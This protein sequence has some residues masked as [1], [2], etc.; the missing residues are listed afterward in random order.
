MEK[1]AEDDHKVLLGMVF[2]VVQGVGF[3]MFVRRRAQRLGLTGW[4]RNTP[5]GAVAV[6]AHG[7]LYRLHELERELL[8]GPPGSRVTRV[9]CDI[10][11]P[12]FEAPTSFDIL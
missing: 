6:Q 4:V 5:E 7:S 9:L 3:R 2:G 11:A 10:Q 12:E 8:K 1:Q